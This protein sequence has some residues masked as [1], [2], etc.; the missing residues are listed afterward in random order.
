[1]DDRGI[2]WNPREAREVFRPK[3]HPAQLIVVFQWRWIAV[4]NTCAPHPHCGGIIQRPPLLE[5]TDNLEPQFNADAQL[6]AELPP[7]RRLAALP[8]FHFSAGKLPH[9]GQALRRTPPGYEQL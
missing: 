4:D 3:G 9:P 1:M 2:R 8:W 5:R 6:L 7:E